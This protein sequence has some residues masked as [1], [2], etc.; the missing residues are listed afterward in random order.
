MAAHSGS[1][2]TVYVALAGNLA[3]AATKLAAAALTG[4]SAMLSEGVH[5]LVDTGNEGLLLYGLH[6]SA[7]PP[8]DTHPLGH[9]RELYFW[10][11]VVALLV[12]SVGAGVSFYEGVTHVLRPEPMENVIVNYAVL[13]LSAIFESISWTIAMRQFRAVKG[14]LG[15][16]AAARRSKD[17]TIF[18]VLFEDSAAL[19]GIAI[20]AIGI[21][22][23][24]ELAIPEL[25]GAASIGIGIVLALT[26]AFLARES[27]GLLIGERASQELQ[28]AIAAAAAEDPAIKAVERVLTVHLSPDQVVAAL[29]ADFDDAVSAREIEACIERLEHRLKAEHQEITSF[30]IRP[31]PAQGGPPG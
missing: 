1:R 7:L 29:T 25:D 17:P 21:F 27:K 30:F 16:L 18:T 28:R 11:F 14:S 9:G 10:S 5:S 3:I 12:F 20:A 2:K 26:A 23:A 6:R 4:S 22:A 13:G 31:R 8:D 19:L 24:H 15:F